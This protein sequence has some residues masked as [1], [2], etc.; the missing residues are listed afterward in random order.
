MLLRPISEGN[1]ESERTFE[2]ELEEVLQFSPSSF[3]EGQEHVIDET[4]AKRA[5]AEEFLSN[6]KAVLTANEKDAWVMK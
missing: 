3:E 4:A 5:R 6:E 1:E 2:D